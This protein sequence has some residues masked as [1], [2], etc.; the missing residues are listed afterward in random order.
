MKEFTEEQQALYDLMSDL[1]EEHYFA[2]WICGCENW[3]W[4]QLQGIDNG[5]YNITAEQ[6]KEL[7]TAK[8]KANGWII[9]NYETSD[10]E[11]LTLEEWDLL[12]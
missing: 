11:F 7:E 3:L 1:S 5:N 10:P 6:R 9:W 8:N 12:K 2:G 4:S